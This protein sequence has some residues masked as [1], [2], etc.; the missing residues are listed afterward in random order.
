M[1]FKNL[2]QL[3][4]FKNQTIQAIL[5]GEGGSKNYSVNYFK[6]FVHQQRFMYNLCLFLTVEKKISR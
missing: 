3:P 6:Q 1:C 4:Y 5:K 2:L